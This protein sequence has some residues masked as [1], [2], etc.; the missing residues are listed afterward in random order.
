MADVIDMT[1]R[2]QNLENLIARRPLEWRR[3]D[4]QA[5]Y[6][7]MCTREES[8]RFESHRQE[9]LQVKG[10]RHIGCVPNHL[11]LDGGYHYTVLGLFRHRDDEAMMRRVYLLAGLM[12]CVTGASSPILRTDLL[13]RIY[14]SILEER[15]R[16]QIL[17]RGNARHFLLPLYAS[18]Y[19]PNL[20]FHR[21]ASAETLKDLYE[22]IQAETDRQ[23]DI[24]SQFYVFYLPDMFP[25]PTLSP[26]GA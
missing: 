26:D 11:K 13:R 12:E 2:F 17:W 10:H 22:S 7:L 21:I 5:G 23:F 18:H 25:I 4:W 20:F 15:E 8:A 24:L 14:K 3:G 6:A 16:L 19:N 1:R 9:A